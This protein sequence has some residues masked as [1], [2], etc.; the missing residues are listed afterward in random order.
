MERRG[1]NAARRARRGNLRPNGAVGC[2]HGWSGAA[3]TRPDAQPVEGGYSLSSFSY[4][5]SPRRGEGDFPPP[6][7]F[8]RPSGAVP[9]DLPFHELRSA[10][11]A[12]GCAPLVATSRGPVGAE[13]FK[14][15][16][17]PWVTRRGGVRR[18]T[19]RPVAEDMLPRSAWKHGTQQAARRANHSQGGCYGQSPREPLLSCS[20]DTCVPPRVRTA[21][22][23]FCCMNPERFQNFFRRSPRRFSWGPR[24]HR[25]PPRKQHDNAR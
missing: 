24:P 15:R 23:S 21:R 20:A 25:I 11:L 14:T 12:A 17:F 1:R 3:A 8:L 9:H 19:R 10:R 6:R 5:L 16:T 22:G 13:E 7:R 4:P 18:R 2:S